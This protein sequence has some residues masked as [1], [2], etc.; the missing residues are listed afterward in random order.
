M[1]KKAAKPK[2][3]EL[4][5]GSQDTPEPEAPKPAS[6]TMTKAD[7][8]CVQ[9]A[10]AGMESPTDGTGFLKSNYG[11]DM[12]NQTWSSYKCSRRHAMPNSRHRHPRA[13][14]AENRVKPSRAI[15][16]HRR[17]SFPPAR[18]I[19]WTPWEAM[20]PLIASLG[21]EQVHRLVELLG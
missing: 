11:I 6:S 16:P 2:S 10:A 15:W 18:A 14:R 12:T 4:E 13:S 19:C 7:A 20:K 3:V 8:V 17:R 1:A 21:K 5:A 9:R